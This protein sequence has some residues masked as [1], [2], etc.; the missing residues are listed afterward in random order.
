MT[1]L[2]NQRIQDF[3]WGE[4]YGKEIY[5]FIAKHESSNKFLHS[6]YT[7]IKY[8]GYLSQKQIQVVLKM[9]E[10]WFNG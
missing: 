9:R 10:A 2:V 6:L 1:N 8:K 3:V 4:R 7:Q 5:D